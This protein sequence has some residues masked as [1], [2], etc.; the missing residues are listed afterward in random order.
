M[1]IKLSKGISYNDLKLISGNIGNLY[2]EG[3]AFIDILKLIEELPL[4][5]RYKIAIQ[6]IQKQLKQGKSFEESLRGEGDIFPDFFA[7]MVAVGEKTGRLSYVLK[8]LEIFYG[9]LDSIKK[10]FFKALSYPITLLIALVIVFL[11]LIFVVVP[12]IGEVYIS[13]NKELP[14]ACEI[15]ISFT[16]FITEQPF[17]VVGGIAFT[18]AIIKYII[19]KN[20]KQIGKINIIRRIPIFKNFN[21]YIIIILMSVVINSGINISKGF[22]YCSQLK[23]IG[24]VKSKLE[25]INNNLLLGEDLSLVME[26]SNLFSKYTIAHIKL[27]EHSGS[28]DKRLQL[29]EE[30]LYEKILFNLNK[31]M[32]LI[33]PVLIVA[34]AV[35]VAVFISV[36]ILPLLDG[37]TTI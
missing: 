4:K 17:I 15:L 21:E 2:D 12:N 36:F 19:V 29:L 34:M 20:F 25:E 27:G 30:E 1:K 33:Q 23:L 8:A 28:L 31:N 24:N 3:I 14:E 7:S 18:I 35:V 5:N 6:N 10:S 22:T 9:K 32:E 11:L 26:K 37:M 16:A 13:L